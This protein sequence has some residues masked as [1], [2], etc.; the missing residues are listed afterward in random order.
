MIAEELYPRPG[1]TA[2]SENRL[3]RRRDP[4]R[5]G[6]EVGRACQQAKSVAREKPAVQIAVFRA[7]F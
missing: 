6:P 2:N 1:V 7:S 4:I 3:A 5:T